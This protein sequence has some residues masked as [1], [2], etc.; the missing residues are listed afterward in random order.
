MA[1]G[2]MFCFEWSS[3]FD[4]QEVSTNLMHMTF[5]N[6]ADTRFPH[7]SG[8]VCGTQTFDMIECVIERFQSHITTEME[9]WDP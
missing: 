7:R 4:V 8:Y 5:D 6:G 1:D 2:T 3:D 9:P